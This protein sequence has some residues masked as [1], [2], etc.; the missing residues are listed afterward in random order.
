[1][2]SPV[3]VCNR[4]LSRIGIDQLI[5]DLNDP[6][7][8]AQAC[9]QHYDDC[10]IEMLQDFPWGF[11]QRVVQLAEV[12]GV[13]VPGWRFA[14]RYPTN[15]L[16]AHV[17]TDS[18][19]GRGSTGNIFRDVWNYDLPGEFVTRVPFSIMA[20]PVTPGA[21]II[22]TDLEEAYLWHT[23]DVADIN[24]FPPLARSALSW[25]IAG[26]IALVLRADTRLHQNAVQQYVWAVSQAQVG[27]QL[28]GVP[29]RAPNPDT[30]RVRA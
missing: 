7:N 10:R 21:R 27:S 9:L 19:G 17:V 3:Q 30:I 4:A 24:Q 29:D 12:N 26:E 15:C 14:Y 2:A 28:E 13:T 5:E 25:K 1:M 11:S 22:V 6:N 8:R 18:A 23:V 20:D 16:Q